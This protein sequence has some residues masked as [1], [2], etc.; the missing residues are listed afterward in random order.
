MYS[1]PFTAPMTKPWRQ[2]SVTPTPERS[3]I[4]RFLGVYDH[5]MI[6]R[7]AFARIGAEIDSF[8]RNRGHGGPDSEGT[9]NDLQHPHLPSAARFERQRGL[10]RECAGRT[11]NQHQPA[12][13]LLLRPEGE[14][15]AVTSGADPGRPRGGAQPPSVVRAQQT[16]RPERHVRVA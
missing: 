4:P 16:T 13:P 15:A 6:N 11:G 10:L 9:R 7:L 12:F 2:F 3:Q 8:F 1:N 5:L 14:R